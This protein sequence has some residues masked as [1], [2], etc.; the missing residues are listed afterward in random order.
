MPSDTERLDWLEEN[1]ARFERCRVG[2][3]QNVRGYPEDADVE[4]WEIEARGEE[5]GSHSGDT[6]RAAI[7]AAMAAE[8][9]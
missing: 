2:G 8:A 1:E 7:D 6:L 5:H 9:P 3:T 4:W